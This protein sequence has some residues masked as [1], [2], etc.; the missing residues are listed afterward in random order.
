M[1]P[2]TTIGQFVGTLNGDLLSRSAQGPGLLQGCTC[3]VQAL[4]QGCHSCVN[5]CLNNDHA[6]CIGIMEKKMETTI[7]YW[8]Y[9]GIMETNMESTTAYWG[10]LGIMEISF[11]ACFGNSLP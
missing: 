6:T 2:Y 5:V 9:T 10:Y 11:S 7:V 1:V 3:S 8:G 4:E